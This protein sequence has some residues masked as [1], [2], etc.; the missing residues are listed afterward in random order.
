[1]DT[2]EAEVLPRIE[3][4]DTEH[5]AGIIDTLGYHT[6]ALSISLGESPIC[7]PV[8]LGGLNHERRILS[9]ALLDAQA[10]EA[11]GIVD[12]SL[13]LNAEGD[14]ETLRFD[15]M[16][17]EVVRKND[18]LEIQCSLPQALHT[19]SK[20]SSKRVR[21]LK[22]MQV[23]AGLTLYEDQPPITGRLRNISI[24]GALLEIPLAASASLK[25]DEAIARLELSFPNDEIFSSMG[26]IRHVNP[27]GRS[28]Y[29]AVG[30]VF[31]GTERAHEQRLMYMVNETERE[32]VYRTG[33]GGRMSFPSPLY[34]SREPG[35]RRHTKRQRKKG[36]A[37]PMVDALLEVARQLHIFLLA[38]Q[39]Q[40]PLPAHCLLDSA[41]TLLTLLNQQRQNLF[42]ALH[43]LH[44]QPG[45]IQHSLNVAVRLG[46]LISAEPEYATQARDAVMAALV[47]DMGKLML[48]DNTLPSIEGQLDTHQRHYLRSHVD[49]LLSAL[50]GLDRLSPSMRHDVIQ[51]INERLD[52]SGYPQGREEAVLSP[53][54]R[55]AAVIDTVDAMTRTRGDRRGK[56]AVEAYRYLYHRPGRFDKHWVTR[57]IQRHG[58]YPIG[59]L[60]KFSSGYLAWVMELDDSGQ[61]RRVRVVRYLGRD[62]RTMNDI[63]SRVDFAQLGTLEGLMRPEGFGLTPY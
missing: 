3:I 27:A 62:G 15:A 47:H 11:S 34:T 57:Y 20:R 17:L 24:G 32:A 54:A 51:C 55:M 58:F 21:L 56:T 44:R 1:M 5:I 39:N 37:T 13:T 59:S 45:W 36:Q 4:R 63:L 35:D 40:R 18:L 38:L 48:V 22:G 33:S 8:T 43:C 25:T 19:T 46:D 6:H 31:T 12:Q 14:T 9:L 7:Y 52:G 30:V 49:V 16:A 50:E 53:I 60:V 26:R 29:A 28:H 42:Y 2:S 61:P 10:L 23:R 41:D